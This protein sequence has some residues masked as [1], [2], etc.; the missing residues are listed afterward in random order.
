MLWTARGVGWRTS[1][2]LDQIKLCF[3]LA[4][5]LYEEKQAHQARRVFV[6]G[7]VGTLDDEIEG[8]AARDDGF[9][10]I[11][12][13]LADGCGVDLG[14]AEVEGPFAQPGLDLPGTALGAVGG[15]DL[16]VVVVV[17]AGVRLG[18]RAL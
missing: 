16:S 10:G 11:T 5:V 15:Q 9:D 14:A 13:L 6:A 7:A 8:A 2:V 1:S 4:A 17:R 12:E 3:C 18:G